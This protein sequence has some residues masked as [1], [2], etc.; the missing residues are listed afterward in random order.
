MAEAVKERARGIR[1][2]IDL[3]NEIVRY[4]EKR[5]FNYSEAVRDLCARALAKDFDEQYAPRISEAVKQVGDSTVSRIEVALSRAI[6][7]LV[8]EFRI[9]EV[10]KIVALRELEDNEP[11]EGGYNPNVFIPERRPGEKEIIWPR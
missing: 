7:E 6:D 9:S 1:V 4:A 8:T 5:G 11:D 3:D 2:P 10:R